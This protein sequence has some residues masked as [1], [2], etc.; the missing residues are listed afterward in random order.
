MS[1][2][3]RR[4]LVLVLGVHRS[5]TSALASVLA[6][7]GLELGF[8]PKERGKDNEDGY[9][10]NPAFRRLNDEVMAAFGAS[11][12]NWALCADHVAQ[13]VAQVP[14]D[15]RARAAAFL[16]GI[17]GTG[18][19]VLKDPRTMATWPF[20]ADLWA[21][22]AF[23]PRLV[24]IARDPRE[25][26]LSIVTRS[27][28]WPSRDAGLTKAEPVHALWTLAMQRLLANLPPEGA[29][30]VRHR[31]LMADPARVAAGLARH[32]RLPEEGLP[33]RIAT[34]A[35][36][37]RP[38]LHRARVDGPV[39]GA[40][41]AG[42][43]SRLFSA[44]E[45]LPS[46]GRIASDDGARIAATLP[47]VTAIL[48]Y[49]GAVRESHGSLRAEVNRLATRLRTA[50]RDLAA[51]PAADPGLAGLRKTL[52]S[53][54]GG[55]LSEVVRMTLLRSQVAQSMGDSA[56]CERLLRRAIDFMPT[57]AESWKRLIDLLSRQ[58]R[59]AE[60]ESARA[61]ARSRCPGDPSF[62]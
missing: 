46:P 37:V 24:V 42:L 62:G 22:S 59:E 17:P 8:E 18:P 1:P 45:D 28:D 39:E 19:L 10:E 34:A 33:D 57:H 44:L 61:T 40:V 16:D 35:A 25:V 13:G 51:L 23:D 41:W 49:L 53:I 36:R 43:S 20:W 12:D 27:A 7:L 2:S 32:L 3:D 21:G 52:D 48:P 56:E 29:A 60:A 14:P 31:D 5:G 15:L 6:G 54:A 50:E 38:I 11:W 55:Q 30:F 26:A 4:L 58:G 47:E 9:Y